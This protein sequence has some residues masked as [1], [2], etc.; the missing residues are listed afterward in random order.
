ME[1]KPTDREAPVQR[2]EKKPEEYTKPGLKRWGSLRE[3]TQGGGG[4]KQEPTH[5][6]F[7]RF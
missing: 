2:D 5:Q 3:L 6:M 4:R 1:A 7:T